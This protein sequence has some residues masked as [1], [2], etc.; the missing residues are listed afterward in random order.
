MIVPLLCTG[1]E[2]C[3]SLP[4]PGTFIHGPHGSNELISH[5]SN[6]APMDQLNLSLLLLQGGGVFIEGGNANFNDCQIYNNEARNVSAAFLA[7][8][9]GPHGSTLLCCFC[10]VVV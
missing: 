5:G 1:S 4:L 2:S 7:L 10:R 9:H 3:P 6:E 8:I